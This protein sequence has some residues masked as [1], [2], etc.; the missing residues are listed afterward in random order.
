MVE[1]VLWVGGGYNK[2]AEK[3]WREMFRYLKEQ[4]KKSTTDNGS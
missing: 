1:T 4:E 3:R 2:E